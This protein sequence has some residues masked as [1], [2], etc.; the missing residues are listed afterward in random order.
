[1]N[2]AVVV[3]N[4]KADSRTLRV[5]LAVADALSVRLGIDGDRL[6]VDL[7]EVATELFDPGAS[8]VN[9][10][11]NDVAASS[12]IIVA[13]PTFKAT[14]TGLLKAFFDHYPTNALRAAVAVGV[15]TGAAPIH[16]L[17]VEVHLRPLL[18]ELGA[19]TPTRGLYVTEQQF[20]DLDTAIG[21]W[22][23]GA[24]PRLAQALT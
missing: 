8:R 21:G 10:L 16:A 17:A 3:G 11:L 24:S 13:S 15:M 5:A 22:A 1:M 20:D 14:Y 23:D 12:L 7:A 9:D 6:V 4:P 19:N 18:V 2:V